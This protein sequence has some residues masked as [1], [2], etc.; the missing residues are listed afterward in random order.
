[1]NGTTRGTI[2]SMVALCAAAA[3][4]LAQESTQELPL[5]G[6]TITK[7]ADALLQADSVDIVINPDNVVAKYRLTNTGPAAATVTLG[8]QIPDLDYSDPDVA[9]SIP[10]S[11]PANFVGLATKIAGKPGGFAFTQT[12]NLNGKD[13]SATLRQNRIS[14]VPVG[15]FQSQVAALSP[16]A[17]ERLSQNGVLAQVGNDQQ[18]NPLY[19]PT[20]TVHTNGTKAWVFQ[21]G[22]TVEIE[23]RYRTSVGASLDTPLRLPLRNER[24]VAAQV[25]KHRTDY[26]IDDAFY[27]GLD[28][29]AALPGP[30][31]VRVPAVAPAPAAPPVALAPPPAQTRPAP[32]PVQAPAQPSFIEEYRPYQAAPARPQPPV[33]AAPPPQPAPPPVA[34]PAPPA[35]VQSEGNVNRLRERRMIFALRGQAALGPIKDFRLVVDKGRPDRVVSFCLENLK[36]ISPTAFEMRA[37]DF[38]P[39]R[40]L[41]V[42]TIGRN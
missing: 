18:G 1:M 13:I 25:Q 11:D 32:R 14:F 2:I 20:W 4:A 21:P 33:A 31:P 29:I 26:C 22:E 17:R 41:K 35:G 5:G 28:K 23:L 39:A 27:V 6:L 36:R 30:A 12:A 9:Y 40:D 38:T 15:V 10:A 24:G 42:L 34:R 7:P 16:D 8:F 37:T 3:P 19:F